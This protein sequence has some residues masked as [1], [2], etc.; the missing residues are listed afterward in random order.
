MAILASLL[1]I[2]GFALG[3]IIPAG[4]T[5]IWLPDALLLFG[6][7]PLLFKMKAK[8]LWLSFGILNFSIG[9]VLELISCLPDQSFASVANAIKVKSHL[10]EHH[11]PLVWMAIG[12]LAF[13]VG[14]GIL[15][16]RLVR[17]LILRYGRFVH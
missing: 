10:S 9:C 16:F 4:S 11:M 12:I 1:W 7:W 13:L 8:W 17:W 3:F 5:Y 6:F 15:G 2:A 14:V